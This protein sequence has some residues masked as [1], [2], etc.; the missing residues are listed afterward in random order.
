MYLKIDNNKYK[1]LM[2]LHKGSPTGFFC[3]EC[4]AELVIREGYNKF[5][6]CSGYPVCKNKY[7]LNSPIS[8][9]ESVGRSNFKNLDRT[10]FE[11]AIR[12]EMVNNNGHCSPEI[13]DE[14]PWYEG[15]SPIMCKDDMW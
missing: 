13:I 6:G 12:F 1:E 10:L 4:G 3:E 11:T 7:S 9:D 14:I 8:F 5:L 15:I 2:K